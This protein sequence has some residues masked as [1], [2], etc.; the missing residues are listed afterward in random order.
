MP[1]GLGWDMCQ[2]FLPG[3]RASISRHTSFK[4]NIR[5]G[6]TRGPWTTCGTTMASTPRVS[7]A[8]KKTP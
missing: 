4:Q 6:V 3:Q 7:R 5:S 2:P 1:V 8:K